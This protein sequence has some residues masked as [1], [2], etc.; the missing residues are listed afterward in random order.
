MM[1]EWASEIFEGI[2]RIIALVEMP[3]AA[4]LSLRKSV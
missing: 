4:H 2:E 3:S 1:L